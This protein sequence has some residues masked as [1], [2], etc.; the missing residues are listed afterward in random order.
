MSIEY[1]L[2]AD[3]GY[4]LEVVTT[5]ETYMGAYNQLKTYQ[6]NEPYH[7]TIQKGLIM[8]KKQAIAEF[9]N[10]IL[11]DIKRSERV[12]HI[13]KPARQMAWNDYTDSLHR[14]GY[15]SDYQVN[16]W[17]QPTELLQ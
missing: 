6:A 11:Y 4:G 10:S 2:M 15:I 3:Y 7:F 1:R 5:E 12:G 9:V 14:N 17:T 16:N 13:D 8:T